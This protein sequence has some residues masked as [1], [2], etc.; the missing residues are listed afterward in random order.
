MVTISEIPF[1]RK[2][3]VH[4][5]LSHNVN[6]HVLHQNDIDLLKHELAVR[7]KCRLYKSKLDP[8]KQHILLLRHANV[9]FAGIAYWLST[10]KG[11]TMTP[12]AISIRVR[13]WSLEHE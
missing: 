12:E 10:R 9:T 11:I 13:K 8:Y 2:I 3:L 7:K 6:K 5:K 1:W 4:N